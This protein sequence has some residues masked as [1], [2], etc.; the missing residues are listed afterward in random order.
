MIK[1]TVYPP[2]RRSKRRL[3]TGK[4]LRKMIKNKRKKEFDKARHN[5]NDPQ[6]ARYSVLKRVMQKQHE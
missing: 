4:M 6:N 3:L 1:A 5:E 2:A